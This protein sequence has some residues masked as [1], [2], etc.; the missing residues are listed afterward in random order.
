MKGYGVVKCPTAVLGATYLADNS[1]LL[2]VKGSCSTWQTVKKGVPQGSLLGLT[3][4][5]IFMNNLFMFIT[6]CLLTNY[7]DDNILS[8][9]HK[10]SPAVTRILTEESDLAT[11]WFT[12]TLC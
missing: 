2:K 4:F 3:M 12:E 7:A 6:K 9:A 5:S 11:G 10:P 8:V 1:A